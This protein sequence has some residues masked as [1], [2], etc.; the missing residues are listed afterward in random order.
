MQPAALGSDG[1]PAGPAPGERASP[2]PPARGAS[3]QL[4][5]CAAPFSAVVK[6][7]PGSS[8]HS[9]STWISVPMRGWG[10]D[11]EIALADHVTLQ[12]GN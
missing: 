1:A 11:V 5:W 2:V 12:G 6:C 8:S 4:R 10:R 9:V 3:P 7:A